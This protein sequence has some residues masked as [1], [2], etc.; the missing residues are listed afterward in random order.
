M[1]FSIENYNENYLDGIIGLYNAETAFEP[2]IAIFNANRFIQL[3]QKKSYFD[4]KGLF[5]AV[6]SGKIVGWIHACIAPGSEPH[7]KP[8]NK[9][10]QIRMLIFPKH[11]IKVGYALVFEANTW[12]RTSGQKKFL[13]IHAQEGYP[14]Y[15][16]LWL[17]SEPMGMS[18]MPHVQLALES[19]GYKNTQES[20]MMTAKIDQM[21]SEF[22]SE[23]NLEFITSPTSMAH[24]PMRESWIGFEPMTT[25]A[26]LKDETIGTIGWVIIPYLTERLGALCLNIWSMGV[27]EKY[28]QKGVASALVS[29]ILRK[30]YESGAKFASVSTQLWNVPAQKTYSKLGFVPYQLTIG[31]TFELE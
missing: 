30:G 2:Y 19:G 27:N 18:A 12:L 21:P 23:V 24:A 29:Y 28:R 7:H 10:P 25:S 14:F 4:P 1:S 20:I 15:R 9:V 13:A 26:I 6:E 11:K 3:V 8:E 17:G 22:R 16:G 31:R 5:V